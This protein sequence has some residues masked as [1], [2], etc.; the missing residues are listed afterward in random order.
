MHNKPVVFAQEKKMKQN[1]SLSYMPTFTLMRKVINC[2]FFKIQ[3][4]PF[5][6]L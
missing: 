4:L 1:T 2:I 3:F 5:I 6:S